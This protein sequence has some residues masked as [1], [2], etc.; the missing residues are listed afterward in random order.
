[1]A[2]VLVVEDDRFLVSAYRA[3][4]EKSGYEVQ[5]ASDGDEALAVLKSFTPDVML[6]DLVMPRRDGFSTLE[7]IKKDSRLD[8]IP[9]IVTS[10]LGQKEDIDKA[11]ALGANDYIIKSDLSIE[12]LVGKI[13]KVSGAKP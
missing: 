3:K 4:L 9:V 6:L 2:K 13:Q 7:E 12:E 10:N 11:M 8:K 1:M 5:I